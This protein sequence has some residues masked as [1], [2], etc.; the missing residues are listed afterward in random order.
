MRAKFSLTLVALTLSLAA[1]QAQ[2]ATQQ[3]VSPTAAV[4]T[5][6]ASAPVASAATADADAAAKALLQTLMQLKA[7]NDEILKRQA[8]TLSQL[9]EISKAAEQLKV[10]STR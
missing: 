10:Y 4:T 8:A 3:L 1:L 5:T 7:A 9:D 6:T 2:T